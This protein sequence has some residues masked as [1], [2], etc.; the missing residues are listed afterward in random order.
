MPKASVNYALAATL[1][2]S[3]VS[4]DDAAREC[5]AKTGTGLRIG[6]YRKGVTRKQA[7]APNGVTSVN[8]SVTLRIA[9]QASD[10]LKRSMADILQS[11]TESL[12]QI[13]AKANLDHIQS[14]GAA[15]EPLVRSAKVVHGWGDEQA[16]GLIISMKEADPDVVV[17]VSSSVT[18]V[19]D[20]NR[21][22]VTALTEIESGQQ[23]APGQLRP[24]ASENAEPPQAGG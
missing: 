3:G 6:L 11:H 23:K 14:V 5:G 21:D 8:K 10:I 17:D 19:A 7:L 20:S 4:F 16:Q 2:A 18:T 1:I 15:L 24:E 12:A 13:P 9:N 22:S